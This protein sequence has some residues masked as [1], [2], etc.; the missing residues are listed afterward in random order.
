MDRDERRRDRRERRDRSRDRDDRDRKR[1]K[2]RSRSREDRRKAKRWVPWL[3]DSHEDIRCSPIE[4]NWEDE[5]RFL[6]NSVHFRF[7]EGGRFSKNID[8]ERGERLDADNRVP[9]PGMADGRGMGEDPDYRG[10]YVGDNG[11]VFHI[12]QEHEIK[13]E[14]DY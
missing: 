5:S 11:E 8:D 7:D 4:V 10:S 3:S 12:K 9:F 14:V 13:H 1:R 2:S 6:K